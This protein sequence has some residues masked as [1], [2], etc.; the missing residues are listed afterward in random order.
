MK[1]AANLLVS[2]AHYFIYLNIKKSY[3]SYVLFSLN[4]Y[5]KYMF[6]YQL[7]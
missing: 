5:L 6:I 1:L 4:Y 3:S 7:S 2:T